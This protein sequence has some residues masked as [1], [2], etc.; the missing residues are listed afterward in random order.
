MPFSNPILGGDT[1]V[2]NAIQSRDYV[3]GVSGWAIFR[4]GTAEFNNVTVRG[5]VIAGGGAVTLTASGIHVQGAGRT[6]DITT[7]TGMF[8]RRDPDDGTYTQVGQGGIAF[9]PQTPTVPN[10]NTVTGFSF[11]QASVDTAGA[12][13]TPKTIFQGP[14]VNGQDAALIT[15]FGET[16]N[17]LTAKHTVINGG[18]VFTDDRL[19]NNATGMDFPSAQ[20]FNTTFAVTIGQT[21]VNTGFINYP[22]AFPLARALFGIPNIIN[23]AA[24]ADQWTARWVP[25]DNTR[26][27]LLLFCP[28]GAPANVS[29][30]INVHVFVV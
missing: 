20:L 27:A 9:E 28:G 22:I 19:V 11:I 26:F 18:T 5:S 3:A 8:A 17:G 12:V 14:A 15:L 25:Q 2:R 6:F 4:D 13:D 21:R 1:L 29:L 24:T 16:S 10:G 23:G 30:S 7:T